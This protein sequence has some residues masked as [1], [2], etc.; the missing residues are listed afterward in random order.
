MNESICEGNTNA[1]NNTNSFI[2]QLV[3]CLML[4]FQLITKNRIKT[5]C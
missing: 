4:L 3:C 2:N 5:N 1:L